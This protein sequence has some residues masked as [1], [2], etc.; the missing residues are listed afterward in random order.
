MYLAKSFPLVPNAIL[1][2]PP[3]GWH[4]FYL[5]YLLESSLLS[6]ANS[7]SA[8]L[9]LTPTLA[10]TIELYVRVI[11]SELGRAVATPSSFSK[12]IGSL[13]FVREMDGVSV[14]RGGA[15]KP[16]SP[17][18]ADDDGNIPRS[19]VAVPGRKCTTARCCLSLLMLCAQW[20][21]YVFG[22]ACK[23]GTIH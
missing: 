15:R 1:W 8:R 21:K 19:E 5:D 6:S 23:I 13:E 16:L 3:L 7:A 2:S 22:S 17:R 12:S 20:F 14:A 11:L 4:Q 9:T 18:G 10:G